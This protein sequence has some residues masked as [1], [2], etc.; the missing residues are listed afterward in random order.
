MKMV[1]VATADLY[2][3]QQDKGSSIKILQS[4]LAKLRGDGAT[5]GNTIIANSLETALVIGELQ[6]KAVGSAVRDAVASL[7]EELEII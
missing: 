4:G 5:P 2:A 1:S 6:D 7:L 3:G